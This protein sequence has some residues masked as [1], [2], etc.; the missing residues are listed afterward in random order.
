MVEMKAKSFFGR[1][2]SP[3][4][5]DVCIFNFNILS[6]LT[7]AFTSKVCSL[8]FVN[9]LIIEGGWS[10]C[11]LDPNNF[12]RSKMLDIFSGTVLR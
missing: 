1:K 6:P 11:P 9:P 12:Q 4:T 7:I 8:R 3:D 10:T 5:E 2:V